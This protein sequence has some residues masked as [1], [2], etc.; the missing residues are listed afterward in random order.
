MT[1][2]RIQLT[3]GRFDHVR[4][5]SAAIIRAAEM[6]GSDSASLRAAPGEWGVTIK[7]VPKAQAKAVGLP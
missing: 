7:P 6:V 5:K 4:G 2:Y 3:N 1:I